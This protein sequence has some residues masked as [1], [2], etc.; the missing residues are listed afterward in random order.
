MASTIGG[1]AQSSATLD[2][3]AAGP[4]ELRKMKEKLPPSRAI[5]ARYPLLVS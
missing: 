2:S 1:S 3:G 5:S 4:L